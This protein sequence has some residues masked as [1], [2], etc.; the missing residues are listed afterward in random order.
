MYESIKN[1]ARAAVEELTETA[2]LK[3]GGLF[4]YTGSV[5]EA[6]DTDENFTAQALRW[7]HSTPD[8]ELCLSRC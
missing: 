6:A 8:P 5:A 7:T 1:Q 4:V 2:Q 3:N